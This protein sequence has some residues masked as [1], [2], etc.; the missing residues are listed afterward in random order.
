MHSRVS[1]YDERVS[2]NV[3]ITHHH[4]TKRRTHRELLPEMIMKIN[5]KHAHDRKRPAMALCFLLPYSA[6]YF[7]FVLLSVR[8]VSRMAACARQHNSI[9]QMTNQFRSSHKCENSSYIYIIICCDPIRSVCES[10]ASCLRKTKKLFT[11][12]I[13]VSANAKNQQ[14][15]NL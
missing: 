13:R 8:V 15:F 6:T 11:F 12:F 4:R 5:H 7:L 14:A 9:Q 2:P 10:K 3:S 1:V